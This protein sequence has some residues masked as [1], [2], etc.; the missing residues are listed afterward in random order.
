MTKRPFLRICS[1]SHFA[2]RSSLTQWSG[3]RRCLPV[4]PLASDD[5]PSAAK[6]LMHP[7]H[8]QRSGP[9][10]ATLNA[11]DRYTMR[12]AA[13]GSRSNTYDMSL[14]GPLGTDSSCS[15]NGVAS[16]S[17]PPP[18]PKRL[19]KLITIRTSSGLKKRS[20]LTSKKGATPTGVPSSDRDEFA[21]ISST[22]VNTSSGPT[23]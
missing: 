16:P 15:I 3:T 8:P 6:K 12:L 11:S 21:L 14:D 23:F 5:S 10:S 17:P 4:D 13:V 7:W 9:W 20:P 1:Y 19:M 18:P 2:K 22:R